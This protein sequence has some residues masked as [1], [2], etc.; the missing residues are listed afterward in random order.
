MVSPVF[1]EKVAYQQD[2]RQNEPLEK[3]GNNCQRLSVPVSP[4]N[5][6]HVK[7]RRASWFARIHHGENRLKIPIQVRRGRRFPIELQEILPGVPPS[8]GGPSGKQ[9]ASSRWHNNLLVSD[10]SAE[11]SGGYSPALRLD[12]MNVTRRTVLSRRQGTVKQDD[13][14]AL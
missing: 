6:C 1:A 7:E 8:V 4:R 14:L 9:R 12:E 3:W 5:V 10:S 13:P 11:R 2:H